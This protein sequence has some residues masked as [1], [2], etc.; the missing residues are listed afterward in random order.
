MPRSSSLHGITV[1]LLAVL[2]GALVA[3]GQGPLQAGES[4]QVTPA[5][6]EVMLA[7]QLNATAIA[8]LEPIEHNIFHRPIELSDDFVHWVDRSYTYGGTQ[9]QA[10]AVHLG[11]EFVNPRDTPVYASKAGVVVYAGDD[12][13][14]LLGPQHDYYGNVVVLS[15][16][17]GS[18]A[19]RQVFSLYGHLEAVEVEAGQIVDDL[20]RIGRI[21]SSGV[22]IGPHLHYEIRV[23]DPF[24]FRLT[25][26][27]ELW[28]QHYVDRGMIVGAIKNE[29]GEPVYGRRIAVRSDETSRDVFSY[30]SDIVN[31]D[32]VWEENFAVGDLPADSYDL[33][34]LSDSGA[35]AYAET[36]DV[37][38]YRTTYLEII[39]A[40][41]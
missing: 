34:V 5:L 3:H 18:L 19:G 24:D 25:R 27:P 22:A 37:E 4:V 26:N 6:V 36:V 29:T 7:P 33:F 13:T 9:L 14:T 32:P 39:L 16:N 23:D 40:D 10:R 31:A 8:N 12:S 1:L 2:L 11:V 21:G 35:V 41:S 38:A 17:V 28:L 20:D 15:H 30:G